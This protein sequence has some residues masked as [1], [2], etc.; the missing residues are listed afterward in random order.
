M[1]NTIAGAPAITP[2]GALQ[3]TASYRTVFD[4]S[5]QYDL[6]AYLEL[7]PT[8][9]NG[10]ITSFCDF[11]G[12]NKDFE[13]DLVIWAE[14]G[15]LHQ[16][17]QNVTVTTD[18]FDCGA[19]EHN[20]RVG[21]TIWISDGVSANVQGDVYEITSATVFKAH[22][23]SAV[24]AFSFSGTV[25]LFAGGNEFAK[26][27]EGFTQGKTWD[28]TIKQNYPHIMKELYEVAKS[29]MAQITW[30]EENKYW[31]KE[32]WENTRIL[33]ENEREITNVF[34]R[35]A[36]SGSN[37]AVAG[38]QGVNGVVPQIYD[39]GIT[40]NGYIDSLDDI[41]D[42][43]RRLRKEGKCKVFTQWNDQE[44]NIENNNFLSGI[45]AYFS[46]GANYGLFDNDK[47]LAL[48]L[49]FHSFERNGYTMHTTR[50]DVLDDPTLFGEDNF[51][52]TGVASLIVPSSEKSVTENG[53]TAASPYLVTRYRKNQNIDRTLEVK[54]FGTPDNPIKKDAMEIEYV[55]EFTNMVIGANEWGVVNR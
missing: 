36:V 7:Y 14:E 4:Y 17:V 47:D 50:L 34:N 23:R 30:L 15:R 16:I 28:P 37:A 12:M 10:K 55:S 48:H 11:M 44:Q 39:G 2:H 31:Y 1:A 19:T 18:S 41:D 32:D 49:D 38:K 9:G 35:R 5:H 25:S 24:G 6:E 13:S 45:N 53:Q 52:V 27:T 40:S 21:E 26:K 46:S 29:D 20:L 8:Y 43:T 51:L 42:W 22:N 54:I 33:F 3:G